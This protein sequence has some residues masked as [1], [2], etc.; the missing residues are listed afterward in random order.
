MRRTLRSISSCFVLP[1]RRPPSRLPWLQGWPLRRSRK[2]WTS[3]TTPCVHT[4]VPCLPRPTW[5]PGL[6]SSIYWSIV[7]LLWRGSRGRFHPC[8]AGFL[9]GLG[10][11]G[12]E[13]GL[14]QGL[15]VEMVQN[16]ELIGIGQR[17]E[18]G[19]QLGTA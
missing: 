12:H 14:I 13:G 11:R 5:V 15:L 2:S 18:L 1:R 10:Q 19:Q 8:P 17:R 4:C 6:S 16:A 9:P 7:R 3:V